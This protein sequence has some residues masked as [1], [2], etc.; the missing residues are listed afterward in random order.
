MSETFTLPMPPRHERRIWRTSTTTGMRVA[1]A[2]FMGWRNACR[3]ILA[4]LPRLPAEVLVDACFDTDGPLAPLLEWVE[5]MLLAEE[6]AR[7]DGLTVL[8]RRST[9]ATGRLA[10]GIVIRGEARAA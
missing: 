7:P 9:V 2:R 8:G 4:G 3:P 1:T 5:A 6:L 10:L